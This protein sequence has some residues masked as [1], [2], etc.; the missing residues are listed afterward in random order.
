MEI[1]HIQLHVMT[2]GTTLYNKRERL[3]SWNL[4]RKYQINNLTKTKF[5]CSTIDKNTP[6]LK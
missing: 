1:A 3:T 5:G 4:T 6:T 2:Q